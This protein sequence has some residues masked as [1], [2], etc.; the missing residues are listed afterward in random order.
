MIV[1]YL[2]YRIGA[3]GKKNDF[4]ITCA[5]QILSPFSHIITNVINELLDLQPL[6]QDRISHVPRK[7]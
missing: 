6:C 7:L 4:F 2:S 5:L 3:P 1:R